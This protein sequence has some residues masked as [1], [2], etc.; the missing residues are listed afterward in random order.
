M[1]TQDALAACEATVRRFDP[2]RYFASLFAP[3]EFRPLLFVLYAF[4]VEIARVADRNRE[5]LL[6]AVRIQWW[7]EA[8]EGAREGRP[9]AHP[10]AIGLSEL[11]ARAAPPVAIF[12]TLLD[13]REFDF[14]ADSFADM[15]SLESYC[16]ATSSGLMRLAAHV[17]GE[18]STDD[19]LLKRAGIAF[20]IAG[21]LRAIPYH[22]ARRK[23]YLPLDMLAA[24][25]VSMEEIFAGR[26]SV[27]L[28]RVM[29]RLSETADR[30]LKS[31]RSVEANG[32][33]VTAALPAALVPL[34]LKRVTRLRFDPFRDSP[35]VPVFRK[36]LALLSAATFGRF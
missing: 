9:R 20:A 13:A 15:A 19:A 34:Y 36:Q 35:D 11:F 14:A 32:Q 12:E 29:H 6:G 33:V 16:D 25:G 5:P 21:L 26:N 2:D 10:V 3:A 27:A 4:N 18:R 8:I 30:H 17:L 28:K 24:G 1:N 7:R 31:L 23:L 22:A